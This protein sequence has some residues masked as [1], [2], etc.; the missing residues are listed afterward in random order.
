MSRYSN[1]QLITD[2]GD[3]STI[4]TRRFGDEYWA[5]AYTPLSYCILRHWIENVS[6]KDRDALQG[7]SR[8]KQ[9]HNLFRYHKGFAYLNS[10]YVLEG[11]MYR[12][13]FARLP[14]VREWLCKKD[15]QRFNSLPFCWW[16]FL[17]GEIVYPLRDRTAGIKKNHL[18]L[19][20]WRRSLSEEYGLFL[21]KNLSSQGLGY[22]LDLFK[23]WKEMGDKHF[24]I[25]RWGMASHGPGMNLA[26]EMVLRKWISEAASRRMPVLITGLPGCV[27][28]KINNDLYKLATHIADPE[29]L[30]IIRQESKASDAIRYVAQHPEKEFP[31]LFHQFIKKYGHRGSS[32]EMIE[33]RWEEKPEMVIDLMRTFVSE[34]SSQDPMVTEGESIRRREE[35]TAEVLEKLRQSRGGFFKVSLFNKILR[36]AQVYYIYRENQRFTLDYILNALKK[37]ALEIGKRYAE[38]GL[39]EDVRHVFF[40]FEDELFD[41]ATS[42]VYRD[43]IK[44]DAA[45]RGE[46]YDYQVGNLPPT[47]LQGSR[48]FEEEHEKKGCEQNKTDHVIQGLAVSPGKVEGRARVITKIEEIGEIQKGEILV[49]SN[50]DPSWTPAFIAVAGLV[51]ETG[52]VLSHG[53]IISREYGIPA[54]TYIPQATEVIKTGQR[55]EV[56]GD[57]GIVRVLLRKKK[58]NIETING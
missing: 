52:G 30:E 38:S 47:F 5:D 29:L 57:R 37:I 34:G 49:S 11:M 10:A 21:Q 53:A 25:I 41:L 18:A 39:L 1:P 36:R 42:P 54:V 4:W 26:L 19:E 33:N 8:L 24:V 16:K 17:R 7:Y 50:T 56:D 31:K 43:Q 27:T 55:I 40:L 2:F 9:Y 48:E 58:R 6:F 22:L 44:R 51:L 46:L 3:D 23:Q 15:Q 45:E 35:F 32:R 12:P 28:L 14:Q 20:Q 13:G